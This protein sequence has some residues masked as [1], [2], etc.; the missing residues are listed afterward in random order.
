MADAK[1]DS[2]L[3]LASAVSPSS[4]AAV[5]VQHASDK[6]TKSSVICRT[7]FTKVPQP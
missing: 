4:L 3:L 1:D 2:L 7:G 5:V 6:T